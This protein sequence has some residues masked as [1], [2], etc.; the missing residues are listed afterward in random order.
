MRRC[1]CRIADRREGAHLVR[2][3]QHADRV[4]KGAAQELGVAAGVGRVD[5]EDAELG[6]HVVVDEVVAA[7]EAG[8]I[9][10]LLER[11]GDDDD[12][13][14]RLEGGADGGFAV[15]DDADLA[16]GV[17][18]GHAGVVGI[19]PR[20]PGHVARVAVAEFGPDGQ[21]QLVAR[22]HRAVAGDD[23]QLLQYRFVLERAGRPRESSRAARG[24]AGRRRRRLCRPHE[25]PSRRACA[26]ASSPPARRGRCGGR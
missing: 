6:E 13:D 7:G 12:G 2:R 18:V 5:A 4:E 17:H 21:L 16:E 1:A 23:L 8:R 3:G 15:A 25:G 14:E 19:E 9:D 24:R 20:Q 22:F 26:A 11:G 10:R